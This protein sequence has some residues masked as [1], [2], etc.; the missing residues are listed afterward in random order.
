MQ[1]VRD[2]Q[3]LEIARPSF[4]GLLESDPAFGHAIAI[5]LARQLQASGGLEEPRGQARVFSI[6]GASAAVDI[7]RF[8][9]TLA[10]ELGGDGAV[11]TLSGAEDAGDWTAAL[12]RAEAAAQNVLLVGDHG[13][14][15]S[16]WNGFVRRHGDRLLLLAEADTAVSSE[17]AVTDLVLLGPMPAGRT[18]E[19]LDA[20][21]PGRTTSSRRGAT[22]AMSGGSHDGC[23]AARSGSFSRAAAPGASRTSV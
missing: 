1:A 14:A 10:A 20:V 12:A 11:A 3:L 23:P 5:E 17:D 18:A 7:A 8:G 16:E 4:D 9:R 15:D 21:S 2:S 22:R 19:W 6:L 13:G